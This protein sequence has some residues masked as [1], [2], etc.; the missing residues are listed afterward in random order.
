M[1]EEAG[2]SGGEPAPV[3]GARVLIGMGA[4]VTQIMRHG[5]H[6]EHTWESVGRPDREFGGQ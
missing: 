4:V 5:N 3:D 2:S 6:D 1:Q